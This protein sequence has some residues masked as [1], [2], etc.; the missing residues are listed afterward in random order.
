MLLLAGLAGVFAWIL[1]KPPTEAPLL[2]LQGKTMGTSYEV[3]IVG[4]TPTASAASD[5][6]A[7]I[8]LLLFR[9]NQ[10]VSHYIADS[11]ISRFNHSASTE[12]MPIGTEFRRVLQAA[13]DIHRRSG[14]AFDPTL[15]PLVDLWGFG[16]GKPSATA[17]TDVEL[18]PVLARTGADK[19]NLT[20]AGLAKSV[21]TLEL[22]LSAIAKGYAVDRVSDLLAES[23]HHNTYVE[24]GGEVSCRGVNAIG[25][26]WRIGVQNPNADAT[27][28]AVRV[29]AMRN[30]ALATSG[31]YRNLREVD[32]VFVNHILDP[33]T[34]KPVGHLLASVSVLAEDCMTAD[35]VATALVVMGREAGMDW[36]ENEPGLDAYFIERQGDGFVSTA[37]PGFEKA[38]VALP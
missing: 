32:G 21:P 11:E 9:L 24:I 18:A 19:L 31:D 4:L 20:A 34:G 37:T 1:P 33:R 36:L 22:N 30:R 25:I 13:L 14:G 38:L 6:Q 29:V 12:A 28:Q 8:D 23:G 17:P 2:V 27:A 10:A 26:P 15:G 35:A 16:P 7:D 5:V 3:K